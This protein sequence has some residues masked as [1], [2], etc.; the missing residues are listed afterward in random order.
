MLIDTIKKVLIEIGLTPV[1]QHIYEHLLAN[2]KATIDAI[3]NGTRLSYAQVQHNLRVLEKLGLVAGPLGKK[4]RVFI[5]ADPKTSLAAILEARYKDWQDSINRLDNELRIR[6]T[7][8]GTCTRRV[9]FYHY[10]DPDLAI[11]H[12]HALI[13]DAA[14]EVTMSAPPPVLLRKLEPALHDAFLRGVDIT[15]YF[16]DLDFDELTEYIQRV[17]DIMRRT[18]VTVVQT[19]EKTTQLVRFNDVVMNMGVVLVDGVL[20]NS[21]VFKDDILWH[22]NGFHGQAFV[23]QARK[24]LDVLNVE[25][26]ITENPAPV[27]SVID[28]IETRGLMKT[29]DIGNSSGISGETLRKILDYLV[30]QGIVA[31]TVEKS[32]KAGRPRKVYQVV[33]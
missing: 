3:K 1:Q 6:E 22:A 31:E 13:R 15:I 19:R 17:L 23:E 2:R 28:A 14:K 4:P 9:S 33:D 26:K 10:T 8:A 27:Q 25:K 12:F 32:G 21:F 30:E 24:F 7:T 18:R 16:S 5:P 20:L 29:R 11:G